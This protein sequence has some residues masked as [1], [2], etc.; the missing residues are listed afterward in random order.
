M[1]SELVL[2]NDVLQN[3]VTLLLPGAVALFVFLFAWEN[4]ALARRTGFGRT[5]VWLLLP[6]G[7]LAWQLADLPLFTYRTDLLA[8]NVAGGLVPVV[9]SFVALGRVTERYTDVLVPYLAAIAVPSVLA[10]LIV[11]YAAAGAAEFLVL[12]VFLAASVYTLGLAWSHRGPS[13]ERWGRVAILTGLTSIGISLTFLTTTPNPMGIASGFPYFLIAPGVIGTVAVPVVVGFRRSGWPTEAALPVAYATTTI[14]TLLGADLLRQPPL[15]ALRSNTVFAIGGAGLG[16][17]VFLSGL[18]ALPLALLLYRLIPRG[19]SVVPTSPAADPPP[20]ALLRQARAAALEG[21][22][23]EAVATSARSVRSAVAQLR[24]LAS[25][26][27]AA[28]ARAPWGEIAVPHWVGADQRNLEALATRSRFEPADGQRAFVTARFLVHVAFALARARFATFGRRARAFFL[29]LGLIAAASAPGWVLFVLWVD[30]SDPSALKGPLFFLVT[31]GVAT[32]GFAYFLLG[33]WLWGTTIGKRLVRIEVT[34]RRLGRP[35]V[36]SALA[37]NIPKL[38][39]LNALAFAAVL[40]G[41]FARYPTVA[42]SPTLAPS[43]AL[44]VGVAVV[45]LVLGL[46]IP[47]LASLLAIGTGREGQRFGDFV[48]GTWVVRQGPTATVPRGAALPSSRRGVD[49]FA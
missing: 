10:T 19:R 3:S 34:D 21:R 33:E 17:L 41:L 12:V 6:L 14:G 2:A 25:L 44:G 4:P 45:I 18:I 35:G 27:P 13:A 20:V 9:V 32:F 28:D 8:V 26:P 38:V 43:V 16:D 29:D 24:R 36:V 31:T 23:A 7:L 39:P 42:V 48:A 49:P 30:P 46:G 40:L 47:G 15:Y 11:V 37:R 5:V 22:T 1:V